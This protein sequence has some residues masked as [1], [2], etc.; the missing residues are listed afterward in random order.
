MSHPTPQEPFSDYNEFN[1]F[2]HTVNDHDIRPPRNE[3]HLYAPRYFN[4]RLIIDSKHRNKTTYPNNAEYTVQLDQEYADVISIDLVQGI[5][6]FSGYGINEYNNVLYFQES[7]NE[8]LK[9]FIPEGNYSATG[10]AQAMEDA[11]NSLGESTYT[12]SVVD[13]QKKFKFTSDWSGGDNIFKLLFEGAVIQNKGDLTE[14][15]TYRQNSIGPVIGFPA[16]DADFILGVG[17]AQDGSDQVFGKGSKFSLS[18]MVGDKIKFEGDA[19]EYEVTDILSDTVLTIIPNKIGD[20][21]G[22][23][24]R[25]NSFVGL[26][27]YDLDPVKYLALFLNEDDTKGLNKIISNNNKI[28]KAFCIIPKFIADSDN[29]VFI[30]KA[31]LPNISNIFHF[32]P[33]QKKLTKLTIKFTDSD[34][35]LYDFNG[36]EHLLEFNIRTINDVGN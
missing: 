15:Q 10:L 22:V 26:N 6:T 12:V 18:T 16:M 5:V 17:F 36:R 29:T 2:N 23:N 25:V 34:G 28:Q 13:I 21:N 33:S 1:E 35:N 19:T 31:S 8:I 9:V 30:N 32:Y 27:S 7:V 3:A 11:M 14:E 24:I 20:S 4:N